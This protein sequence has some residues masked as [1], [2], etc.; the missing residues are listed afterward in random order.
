MGMPW[1]ARE[2]ETVDFPEAMPPVSPTTGFVVRV[3]SGIVQV[4]VG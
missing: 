4:S 2:R 1:A 3:V